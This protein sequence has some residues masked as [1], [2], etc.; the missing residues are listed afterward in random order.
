MAGRCEPHVLPLVWG[1]SPTRALRPCPTCMVMVGVV[2]P[3]AAVSVVCAADTVMAVGLITWLERV[4]MVPKV[5]MGVAREALV[6]WPPAPARLVETVPVTVPR[7]VTPEGKEAELG[8]GC[9]CLLPS[10]SSHTGWGTLELLAQ[11]VRERAAAAPPAVP[12]GLEASLLH[13]NLGAAG[14]LACGYTPVVPFTTNVVTAGLTAETVTGVT[15]RT[16]PMGTV[17]RMVPGCPGA[18]LSTTWNTRGKCH[19]RHHQAGGCRRRCPSQARRED[20]RGMLGWTTLGHWTERR[21]G[22]P[23]LR[24]SLLPMT[25]GNFGDSSDDFGR[26]SSS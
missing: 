14:A 16:P 21:L 3:P 23:H 26:C 15:R 13:Y 12:R 11:T 4:A 2:S 19:Q 1:P 25:S 5:V 22:V 6:L 17:R 24:H 18:P 20:L 9:C 10:G 8:Q 7:V